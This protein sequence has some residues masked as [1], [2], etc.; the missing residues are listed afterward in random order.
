MASYQTYWPRVA[1]MIGR[2]DLADAID[3]AT[4]E[5]LQP[6]LPKTVL[7]LEECIAQRRSINGSLFSTST[8]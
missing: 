1:R 4:L 8:H 5:A 6:R 7:L 2:P 3:Y